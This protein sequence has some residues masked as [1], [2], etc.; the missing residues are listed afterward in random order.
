VVPPETRRFVKRRARF[1]CEYCRIRAWPLTVDHI[2]PRSAWR[3]SP[4]PA[5]DPDDPDNLAAA[6]W[7]CNVLGKH[8]Q[9]HG[10]D[11]FSGRVV[12]LFHPRRDRWRDHFEWSGDYLLLKGKTSTGWATIRALGLNGA[13]Y[14]AQRRL[15][16]QA[17]AA[18]GPAW[19]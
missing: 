17:M 4:P 6:C 12:P 11:P 18:G 3:G 15:L 1:R 9:T 8:A 5:G 19:P 16:R 14:R 2:I 7:E 13:R 10:V